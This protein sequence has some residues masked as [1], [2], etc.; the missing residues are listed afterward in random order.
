MWHKVATDP[1]LGGWGAE[2]TSGQSWCRGPETAEPGLGGSAGRWSRERLESFPATEGPDLRAPKQATGAP[3]TGNMHPGAV[4]C[5]DSD[6]AAG[7]N[8]CNLFSFRRSGL[9]SDPRAGLGKDPYGTKR[10]PGV[11]EVWGGCVRGLPRTVLRIV[12]FP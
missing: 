4:L 7:R 3:I 10:D 12:P 9:L 5:G 1:V 8:L 2:P 11:L 6:C